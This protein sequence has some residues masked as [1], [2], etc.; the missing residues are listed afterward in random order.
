MDSNSSPV[1]YELCRLGRTFKLS[2]PTFPPYDD[3]YSCTCNQEL[4]EDDT[5]EYC[6][7]RGARCML[8]VTTSQ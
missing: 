6:E 5:H 1:A 2:V 8:A 7:V 4:W 3:C